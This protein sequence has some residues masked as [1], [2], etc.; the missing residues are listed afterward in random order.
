MLDALGLVVL[1]VHLMRSIEILRTKNVRFPMCLKCR[2]NYFL[3]GKTSMLMIVLMILCFIDAFH[4][5]FHERYGLMICDL[6]GVVTF[7]VLAGKKNV[8]HSL[9]ALP[10]NVYLHKGK[11]RYVV[12]GGPVYN[13]LKGIKNS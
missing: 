5:G 12:Y 9:Q 2:L 1:P 13:W 11:Y 7:M 10:V 3:P 4:N 6:M 8:Q